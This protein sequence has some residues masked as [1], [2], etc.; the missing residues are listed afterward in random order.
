MAQNKLLSEERPSQPNILYIYFAGF[1]ANPQSRPFEYDNWDNWEET[2]LNDEIKTIAREMGQS[3]LVRGYSGYFVRHFSSISNREELG[4]EDALKD[5]DWA[6]ANWPGTQYIV[7]S[8]SQGGIFSHLLVAANPDVTFRYLIDLDVLCGAWSLMLQDFKKKVI[9]ANPGRYRY[10]S[11]K[12]KPYLRLDLCKPKS[13]LGIP[14]T[15]HTFTDLIPWHVTYNLEVRPTL[16][17]AQRSN[18]Y[19][20]SARNL[21]NAIAIDVFPNIRENG[22]RKNIYRLIDNKDLHGLLAVP[23]SASMQWVGNT[24]RHIEHSESVKQRTSTR[25]K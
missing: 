9:S 24:I 4:L 25:L 20:N 11:E 13:I 6:K 12:I 21:E 16:L 5:M 1:T 18:K 8:G 2:G 17:S 3:I 23:G 10:I 19:S 22:S 15:L 14:G 7:V